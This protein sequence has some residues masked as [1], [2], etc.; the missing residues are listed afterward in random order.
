MTIITDKNYTYITNN[1]IDRLIKGCN[2]YK[3]HAL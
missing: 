2:P 1:Y 3:T